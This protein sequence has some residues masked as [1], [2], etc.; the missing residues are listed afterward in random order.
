MTE[1]PKVRPAIAVPATSADN[2]RD[3]PLLATVVAAPFFHET[4]YRV[5]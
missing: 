3:S 5:S 2:R 1:I 4:A